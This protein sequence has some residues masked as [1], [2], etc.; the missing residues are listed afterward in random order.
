MTRGYGA[1]AVTALV[2]V[3]LALGN[4]QSRQQ[5]QQLQQQY[6]NA[7]AK[8]FQAGYEYTFTYNGQ[9][10]TGLK[11]GQSASSEPQQ[12]A[13]T[14]I[15]TQCKIQFQ[16]NR[17]A[18]L[19]L[20]QIRIGYLNQ[21][22]QNPQQVK[23]MGM[24]EQKQIESEKREELQLPTQFSYV[25]GVVERIEFHPEDSTWSKNIKRAVLNMIQLNLKRNNAQG[26]R[27]TEEVNAGQKE[28]QQANFN[29][30]DDQQQQGLQQ[31]SAIFAQNSFTI[32]EMTIEG[33]CQTT[34]TVNK[35]QNQQQQ[36]QDGSSSS[37]SNE[38]NEEREQQQQS[39]S[40]PNCFNVTKSIDFKKCNKI[41][42]VAF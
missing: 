24:F 15:Q 6:G 22:V 21:L 25:D 32:P 27:Q 37:E 13:S 5:Q 40:C 34:Y 18:T 1:L 31:A 17:H 42:D 28:Q 29:G 41:A 16:S 36:Q 11:D 10:S 39:S 20:E 38:N 4:Q 30:M 9:I 14:R 7:N 8:P 26:S 33:E 2:L 12:Q 23:P 19:R 3:G 35:N